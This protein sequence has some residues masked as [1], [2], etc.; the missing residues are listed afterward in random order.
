MN[1]T[2]W[3]VQRCSNL[4][5]LERNPEGLVLARDYIFDKN[6]NLV[7][8]AG[9]EVYRAV[10]NFQI[11]NAAEVFFTIGGQNKNLLTPAY[12]TRITKVDL[13]GR[14]NGNTIRLSEFP[15][16]DKKSSALILER[17]EAGSSNDL[18]SSCSEPQT[19]MHPYF[20]RI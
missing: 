11:R 15:W 1:A 7:V 12:A 4:T 20:Y 8:P 17:I 18:F 16:F 13:Q 9:V 10:K 6:L 3:S 2:Y 5:K 19:G 14:I